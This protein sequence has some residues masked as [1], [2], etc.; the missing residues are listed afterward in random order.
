MKINSVNIHK[1]QQIIPDEIW[2]CWKI[3]INLGALF[4]IILKRDT[5]KAQI[6]NC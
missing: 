1:Q 3:L 5:E 2:D 4:F 6:Y